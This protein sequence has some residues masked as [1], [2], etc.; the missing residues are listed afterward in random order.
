MQYGIFAVGGDPAEPM[1]PYSSA[2]EMLES[3]LFD[4]YEVEEIAVAGYAEGHPDIADDLLARELKSKLDL[5]AE[6][7][8]RS[9]II[10]RIWFDTPSHWLRGSTGWRPWGF[11]CRSVLASLAR[12]ASNAY[13]ATPADLGSHHQRV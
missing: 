3:E 4:D 11:R 8:F 6:R 7:D 13:W 1:G 12:P 2:R 5:L 9:L 10:T